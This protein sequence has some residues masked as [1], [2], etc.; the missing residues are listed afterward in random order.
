MLITGTGKR[1]I[2]VFDFKPFVSFIQSK[3]DR[4]TCCRKDRPHCTLIIHLP[5][6]IAE[7]RR[8]APDF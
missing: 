5:P 1:L 2:T 4:G 3:T 7:C 6:I 8:E